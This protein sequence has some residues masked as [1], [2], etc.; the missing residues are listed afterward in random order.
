MTRQL[1]GKTGTSKLTPCKSVR[2]LD[3]LT[4]IALGI[5]FLGLAI[6]LSR[7]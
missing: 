3:A 4:L 6:L 2:Q 5:M 7:F 1:S